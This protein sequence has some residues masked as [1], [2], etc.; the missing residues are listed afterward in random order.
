MGP[1]LFVYRLP[2]GQEWEFEARLEPGTREG[3][4]RHKV[5]DRA[6]LLSLLMELEANGVHKKGRGFFSLS[7]PEIV[8]R[9]CALP[10]ENADPV[11]VSV[12]PLRARRPVR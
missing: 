3:T 1:L 12:G 5:K 9:C 8:E 4:T 7:A 11:C 10:T 2:E 6:A